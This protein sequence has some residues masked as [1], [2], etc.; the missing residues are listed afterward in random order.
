MARICIYLPDE[1]KRRMSKKLGRENWSAIA[2]EAWAAALE[3]KVSP[4][5]AML[6]LQRVK[7]QLHRLER[8][9]N[10]QGDTESP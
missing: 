2:Q 3:G 7:E 1:L 9:L 4:S 6:E 5:M 10:V 8:S